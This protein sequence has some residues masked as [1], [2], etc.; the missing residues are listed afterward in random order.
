[1]IQRKIQTDLAQLGS[2]WVLTPTIRYHL[3][4]ALHEHILFVLAND[5]SICYMKKRACSR[6]GQLS[7]YA[8]S[9][10]INFEVRKKNIINS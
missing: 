1:M 2:S 4:K 5:I 10:Q 3:Y 8:V 6:R 9:A 7:H